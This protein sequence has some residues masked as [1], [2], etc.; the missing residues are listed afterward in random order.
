MSDTIICALLAFLGVVGLFLAGGALDDGMYQF[1]LGLAAFAVFFIVFTI[2]R[3]CDA[4]DAARR[5]G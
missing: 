2:K 4:Q 5:T 1:G 3:Y